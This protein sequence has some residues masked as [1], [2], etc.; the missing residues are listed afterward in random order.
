M[1]QPND[2]GIFVS[3]SLH[4][5]TRLTK[6][7]SSDSLLARLSIVQTHRTRGKETRVLSAREGPIDISI[8]RG[9]RA[10]RECKHHPRA[11]GRRRAPALS[12]ASMF[13]SVE[14]GVSRGPLA[15]FFAL[16]AR[17]PD[18]YV[19]GPCNCRRMRREATFD[20]PPAFRREDSA[21]AVP[22]PGAV[23]ADLFLLV[24]VDVII[25][26]VIII[27]II[28]DDRL[29]ENQYAS[30]IA[31]TV[32]LRSPSIAAR[33]TSNRRAFARGR[34]PA[35]PV[36]RAMLAAAA[37]RS[38]TEAALPLHLLH[39]LRTFTPTSKYGLLSRR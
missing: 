36:G 10:S 8:F 9:S 38:M 30:T 22:S 2:A 16:T 5:S 25:V 23:D 31:R 18:A 34:D 7:F 1:V 20:R 24:V 35:C 26:I 13:Q 29:A 12:L 11:G 33:A 17:S 37:A 28:G 27:V 39:V 14:R 19:G 4:Q 32:I 3:R 15:L 6:L 21:F